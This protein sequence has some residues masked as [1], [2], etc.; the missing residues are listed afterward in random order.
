M[1][2]EEAKRLRPG[3]RVQWTDPDAELC[4]RAITIGWIGVDDYVVCIVDQ[5]GNCLKGDEMSTIL[6]KLLW[7]ELRGKHGE[8]ERRAAAEFVL[9]A[10]DDN[11]DGD[12]FETAAGIAEDLADAARAL[13]GRIRKAKPNT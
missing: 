4:S 3:D 7:F 5:D 13:A 10:M 1:T 8:S 12:E 9:D 2:L 6:D 11:D